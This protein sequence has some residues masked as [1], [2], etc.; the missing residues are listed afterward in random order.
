M[1]KIIAIFLLIS[2]IT[3]AQFW[4]SKTHAKNVIITDILS[5]DA[6]QPQFSTLQ[7]LINVTVSS[8]KI[9]GGQLTASDSGRVHVSPAHVIFKTTESKT[10]VTSF[11]K[12]DSVSNLSLTDSSTNYIIAYYNNG[13]PIVFST[14]DPTPIFGQTTVFLSAVYRQGNELRIVNNSDNGF[15]SF[16]A[17]LVLKEVERNVAKGFGFAERISGAK[18]DS[19]NGRYIKI[20]VGVFYSGYDRFTN[21]SF[22]SFT[23]ASDT[24]NVIY[25]DG[26]GGFIKL[27]G[28]KQINNTQFDDG[29]GTLHSLQVNRF[30]NRWLYLSFDAKKIDVVLGRNEYVLL[31]DALASSPPL[32][33]TLPNYVST[34]STPLAQIVAQQGSDILTIKLLQ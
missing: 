22:N 6:T 19:T 7:D 14:I 11:A 25:R 9:S 30:S 29:T 32:G 16:F 27:T 26:S 20:D 12:T 13:N 34:F 18:V 1:K 10:G 3:F 8:G 21:N 15:P 23:T 2:Q 28:G 5:T 31:N 17:R 33:S 4:S 24:F